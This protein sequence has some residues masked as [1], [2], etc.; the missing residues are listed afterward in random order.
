MIE[1]LDITKQESTTNLIFII[2]KY[3]IP[4][5]K[6]DLQFSLYDCDGP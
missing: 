6:T 1:S 4:K 2:G 5:W 3:S